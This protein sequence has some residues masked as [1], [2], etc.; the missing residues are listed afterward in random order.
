MTKYF[1]R[2]EKRKNLSSPLL[3]G[4]IFS[5]CSSSK[6]RI[7]MGQLTV[8][9]RYIIQALKDEGFTQTEIAK[10]IAKD[11]SVVSREI[12]R[13]CDVRNGRYT[14]DLAE[15]KCRQR[16]KHK[17]KR[18][19]FT[20]EVRQNIE[21][22]LEED[23]SPEQVAGI[24]RVQDT[25]CVSHERI[26]QHIWDDKR[27]GG[28]LYKHLR[29]RGKRYRKRGALKDKRG[30]IPDKKS[31]E[32]R[33][34]IVDKKER[35]GDLEID[36]VIGKNHKKAILTVNDRAT[37]KAK[38]ALLES[39]TSE[40]V[41]ERAIEILKEWKPFLKTITSD[42]GKEFALHKEIA[43][44]LGID[45]YFARPYHSWERGA[46]ENFNGLLRQYFPKKYDFNLIT[47][48]DIEY[49]ENKLNNRPRKRFGFLTPN[50][51]HLQAINNNGQVAFIT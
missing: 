3:N 43:D 32:N 40:E 11:K 19:C 13:N 35:I 49:A 1:F 15:R 21:K 27:Q 25:P 44:K 41:K 37:G 46:N 6:N 12:R 10:R 2:K 7:E 29:S 16:H 5:F 34:E 50:Q 26:Y 31:I 20:T 38:I 42:N 17:R 48:K 23:Y 4:I 24:L 47:Q 39:K 51:V 36:L 45:Y 33:P 30:Q 9:Q 28:K 22:L 18:L 8:E 14:A